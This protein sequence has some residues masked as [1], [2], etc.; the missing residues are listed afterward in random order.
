MLFR[1]SFNENVTVVVENV[2]REFR[3]I[4]VVDIFRRACRGLFPT[5]CPSHRGAI[6]SSVSRSRTV[7]RRIRSGALAHSGFRFLGMR[8]SFRTTLV[9]CS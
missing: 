4:G 9:R 5:L 2:F 8:V 3:V 7:T 6:S 1:V